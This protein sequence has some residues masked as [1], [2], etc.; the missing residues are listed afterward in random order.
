MLSF[1]SYRNAV[2]NL[3]MPSMTENKVR[4]RIHYSVK[5]SFLFRWLH[6]GSP[7]FYLVQLEK[8]E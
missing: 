7:T 1:F 3:S 4:N 6:F 5:L 8:S 2:F